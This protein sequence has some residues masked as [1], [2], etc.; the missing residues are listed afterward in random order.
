M[1]LDQYKA[2]RLSYSELDNINTQT[3]SANRIEAYKG[4]VESLN[5]TAATSY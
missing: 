3:S 5:E 1:K 4:I 2:G